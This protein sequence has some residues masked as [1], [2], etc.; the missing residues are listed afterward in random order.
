MVLDRLRVVQLI[1]AIIIAS[2]GI[3]Y[4]LA[5][6]EGLRNI[7]VQAFAEQRKAI[8]IAIAGRIKVLYYSAL[9]LGII[10]L[11][12]LGRAS[13]SSTFMLTLLATLF[14][15]ADILMAIKFN[16]P[17]NN[18]F[19]SYPEGSIGD[20]KTLQFDWLKYIVIRGVLAIMAMI[21][22]LVSWWK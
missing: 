1:I 9:L 2:Q 12:I 4:I 21:S 8:D 5:G 18:A 10:N 7:S 13:F 22:L 3:F 6:A 15:L 17:I 11:V 20:W 14:T 16:V 19:A